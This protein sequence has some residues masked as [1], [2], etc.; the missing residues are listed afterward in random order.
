MLAAG[1]TG[2]KGLARQ[3][4]EAVGYLVGPH[5]DPGPFQEGA[6]WAC[7]CERAHRQRSAQA[8]QKC[9][10]CEEK[11]D[12]ETPWSALELPWI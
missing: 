3:M 11:T 1:I 7:E 9:S 4:A 8:D 6:M 5:C 2:R 12:S 10:R